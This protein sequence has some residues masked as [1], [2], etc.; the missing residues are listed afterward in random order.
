M[1][2]ARSVPV[3]PNTRRIPATDAVLERGRIT[4]PLTRLWAHLFNVRYRMA[5]LDLSHALHLTGPLSG[6][7]GPTLRG[8]LRDWT[9]DEMR[10]MRSLAK[11]LVTLPLKEVPADGD[12]AFAGPPF[13][14]PYT[15]A[16][17]DNERDRWRTHLA[18]LDTSADLAAQI[19]A[20][21]G[22]DPVLSA[23]VAADAAA[24]PVVTAGT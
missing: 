3:D 9:F 24:R 22:T 15:L 1:S 19:R 12:A 10:T 6:P 16:L 14:L 2:P 11:K 23:L 20:A 4:H 17:P 13:E 21:G 8:H 18:L 7:D 5:F